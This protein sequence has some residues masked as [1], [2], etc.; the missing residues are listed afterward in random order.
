MVLVVGG[1]ERGEGGKEGGGGEKKK[2]NGKEMREDHWRC[3]NVFVGL[4]WDR[5]SAV[6]RDGYYS[7]AVRAV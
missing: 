4:T 2:E 6:S 5:L 3:Y 1:G 7:Y